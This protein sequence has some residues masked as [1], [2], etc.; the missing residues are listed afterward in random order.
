[1][2]AA[3]T[4]GVD[5]IGPMAMAPAMAIRFASVSSQ[6][7]LRYSPAVFFPKPRC[8]DVPVRG[9]GKRGL[10]RVERKAP[11]RRRSAGAA[12]PMAGSLAPLW[13]GVPFAAV[14]VLAC[15]TLG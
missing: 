12:L 6:G 4:S 3:T 14:F 7:V 10:D 5:R 8:M 11:A 15:L 13:I 9:L 1:M 2:R